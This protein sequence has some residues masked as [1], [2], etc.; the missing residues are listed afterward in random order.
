M[1]NLGNLAGKKTDKQEN[2]ADLQKQ[3]SELQAKIDQLSKD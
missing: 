3:M 1:P 2:L